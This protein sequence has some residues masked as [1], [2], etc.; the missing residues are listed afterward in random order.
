MRVALSL[1][2]QALIGQFTELWPSLKTMDSW[3]QRN[4]SPLISKKV[5]SYSVGR[6]FFLFD[7]ESKEDK[8][9][10]SRNRPYF[11]GP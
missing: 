7:F 2:D 11:M 9:L 1:A 4:W 5:A 8:D 6:G 10:I 3:V